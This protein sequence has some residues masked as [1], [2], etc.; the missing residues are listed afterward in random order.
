MHFPVS[1]AH[2]H[3]LTHTFICILTH[4]LTHTHMFT[5]TCSTHITIIVNK[6]SKLF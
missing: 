4:S 6:L 5:Y 2:T 1:T 3:T